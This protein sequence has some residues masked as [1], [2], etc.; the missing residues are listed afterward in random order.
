[1]QIPYHLEYLYVLNESED[2]TTLNDIFYMF[3]VTKEQV[4]VKNCR[5]MFLVIYNSWFRIYEYR[6]IAYCVQINCLLLFA[7]CTLK[8]VSTSSICSK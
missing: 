8:N 1:V 5:F 6:R 4:S 3:S 2:M 7:C